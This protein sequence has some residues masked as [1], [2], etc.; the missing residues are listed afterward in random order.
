MKSS[1][2]AQWYLVFEDEFVIAHAKRC[3]GV[4]ETIWIYTLL[5]TNE[6]PLSLGIAGMKQLDYKSLFEPLPEAASTLNGII[7]TSSESYHILKRSMNHSRVYYVQATRAD[8]SILIRATK[9]GHFLAKQ[10]PFAFFFRQSTRDESNGMLNENEL[11][12]CSELCLQSWTV[13]FE[14]QR[15]TILSRCDNFESKKTSI[16]SRDKIGELRKVWQM[17]AI[18]RDDNEIDIDDYSDSNADFPD[19]PRVPHLLC[20]GTGCAKPSTLRGSSAYA[21]F[22][23]SLLHNKSLCLTAILD[24]GDGILTSINRYLPPALGPADGQLVNI[25]FIWISHSHLDH[26]GGLPDLV[27]AIHKVKTRT[28]RQHKKRRLPGNTE[29]VIVAPAK[30]LRYLRASLDSD[31]AI[32]YRGLTHRDFEILP[33]NQDV[34][35]HI[36]RTC[37]IIRSIPVEHCAH[38]HALLWDFPD[39]FRLCYSG[40]TRP[41]FNLIRSAYESV[42]TK[43]DTNHVISLLLHEATFDDDER[44]KKEALKKKHSTVL[45]AIDVAQKIRAKACLLSHFSQRYPKAPPGCNSNSKV[46]YAIDGLW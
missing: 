1:P 23:P 41:S 38:A 28:C 40:D 31:N 5:K 7:C 12:T 22:T 30:V 4:D 34:R 21:V 36:H 24:C 20:L 11:L 8:D 18:S 37:G 33:Y 10:I 25:R 14:T 6:K 35:Q 42:G 16:D 45:E 3:Y 15:A 17:T 26:Y 9:Q 39:G 27:S 2:I 29:L 43:K 19:F 46:A 13:D 44:G 32:R